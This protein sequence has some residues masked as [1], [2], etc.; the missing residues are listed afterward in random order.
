TFTVSLL[1]A[2]IVA[3]NVTAQTEPQS[4]AD[5]VDY[6]NLVA[7]LV[8]QPG[9]TSKTVNVS[10]IGD[11]LVEGDETFLVRLVNANAVIARGVGVGTIRDNDVAAP[12]NQAAQGVTTAAVV[13]TPTPTP[14]RDDDNPRKVNNNP[15]SHDDEHTEGRVIE[16]RR[17]PPVIVIEGKYGPIELRLHGDA[18]D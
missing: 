4:A 12:S 1:P 10:V 6:N 2:N 14:K 15:G 13:A 9:E 16:I 17:E 8:F 3:V 7:P 18:R 5:G 11:T